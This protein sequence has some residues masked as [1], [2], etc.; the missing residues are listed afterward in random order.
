MHFLLLLSQWRVLLPHCLDFFLFCLLLVIVV[1]GACSSALLSSSNSEFSPIF[2]S[3]L[4]P[5]LLYEDRVWPL[6]LLPQLLETSKGLG[7]SQGWEFAHPSQGWKFAHRYFEQIARFLW[8]KD[9]KSSWKR[10]NHS[11]GKKIFLSNCSFLRAIWS[12]ISDSL[13][14][15]LF[16]ERFAHGRS[17]VMRESITVTLLLRTTRA[18]R[19]Q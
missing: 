19:S 2:T 6:Q 16:T 1:L 7:P 4:Y 12:I 8:A 3:R 18:F 13:M 10:A 15:L 17:F 11:F 9:Q 14:S 5:L